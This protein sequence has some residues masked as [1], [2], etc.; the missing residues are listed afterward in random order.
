LYWSERRKAVPPSYRVAGVHLHDLRGPL[1]DIFIRM[2]A[3]GGGAGS[4]GG[5]QFEFI[6]GSA[7]DDE[8]ATAWLLT[9]F[10]RASFAVLIAP[11]G[12]A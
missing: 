9:F 7:A 6:W 3:G 11:P 8:F 1:F 4:I 2:V 10:D 12:A 5:D